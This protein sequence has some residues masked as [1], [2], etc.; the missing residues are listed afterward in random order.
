MNGK[1]PW[2]AGERDVEHSVIS[3]RRFKLASQRSF[4]PRKKR[5]MRVAPMNRI[6]SARRIH[7]RDHQTFL[8]GKFRSGGTL[9][10]C[11]IRV[12]ATRNSSTGIGREF[13]HHC[14]PSLHTYTGCRSTFVT[15]FV[16]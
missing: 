9:A 16:A 10:S 2:T 11:A 13:F 4:P 8:A 7:Q 5:H 14:S 15:C 3:F 12:L 6:R 1:A